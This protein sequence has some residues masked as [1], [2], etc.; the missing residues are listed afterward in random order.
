MCSGS[1]PFAPFA[2]ERERVQAS[3]RPPEDGAVQR[4]GALAGS[5][6]EEDQD[7]VWVCL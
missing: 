2:P 1:A 4:F 5:K 3:R 7:P 6:P